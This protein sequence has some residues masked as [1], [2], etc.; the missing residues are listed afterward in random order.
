MS[1]K[2]RICT[3]CFSFGS[4][5]GPYCDGSSRIPTVRAVDRQN[6]IV[7]RDSIMASV[8]LKQP[9]PRRSQDGSNHLESAGQA[10]FSASN[11]LVDWFKVELS[12]EAAN[13]RLSRYGHVVTPKVDAPSGLAT[14]Q[15]QFA[16][17]CAARKHPF[18]PSVS[19]AARDAVRII[20][21][22]LRTLSSAGSPISPFG[23]ASQIARLLFICDTPSSR[24]CQRGRRP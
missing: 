19:L 15:L 13:C 20:C 10:R 14:F 18:N 4:E 9:R 3:V 2:T 12:P 8:E 23:P 22:L 1:P 7:M 24:Q 11:G 16:R 21:T 6:A 17:L 5:V